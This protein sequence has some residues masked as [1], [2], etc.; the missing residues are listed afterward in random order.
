MTR[1]ALLT[2]LAR[3]LNKAETLDTTTK[4]RLIEF[5]NET[6]RELLTLPGLQRLRD[7]TI[8]FASVADQATYALPTT[9]KISRIFEV[10]NDRLLKPL[11]LA[12]Y[13]ALDVDP[14]ST[15]GTSDAWVW[16]GYQPVAAAPSNASSIFVKST[17]ASDTGTCYLEGE[18]TGGYPRV[19]SVTMTGTTAVDVSTAVATWVRV[20]KWYLSTAAVGTVTLHEDSGAGTELGRIGIGQTQQRYCAVALYP[21]PSTAITYSA[22]VTLAITD[23]AQDTDEPRLPPDFH[24]LLVAGAMVREYEKMEDNRLGVSMQ[25]YRAR[26]NDLLYWMHETASGHRTLSLARRGGRSSLGPWYPAGS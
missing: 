2:A 1:A 12:Q 15:V 26:V 17:S 4:N 22:D 20:T 24:D 9:A 3:R 25:R 21:T 16:L 11:T 10:T 18:T 13:R 14:A 23:L 5:L 6:H 8:T 7:D 19:V